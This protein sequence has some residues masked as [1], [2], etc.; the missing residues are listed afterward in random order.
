MAPRGTPAGARGFRLQCARGGHRRQ[1]CQ[2]RW[3]RDDA[4]EAAGLRRHAV[5]PR[6]L[7]LRVWRGSAH[8]P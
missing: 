8:G 7:R 1:R 4:A 3:T 2:G 5:R 6:G